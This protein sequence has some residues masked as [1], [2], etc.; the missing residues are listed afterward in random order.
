M[1]TASSAELVWFAGSD[2]S[3]AH[4]RR[5]GEDAEGHALEL[6]R[7]HGLQTWLAVHALHARSLASQSKSSKANR[8]GPDPRLQNFVI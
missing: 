7:G 2:L 6:P 1:L 5:A 8:Y 3:L 4:S